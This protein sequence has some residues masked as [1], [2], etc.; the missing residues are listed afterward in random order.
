MREAGDS[1]TATFIEEYADYLESHIEDW[2][3]TT[4]GSLLEGQSSY[5]LRILPEQ[6]GQQNPAED[7][8]E[9]ILNIANHA[10]GEES[11]FPAR[12]VVDGDFWNWSATAFAVRK[13]RTSL[14]PSR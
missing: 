4:T 14:Q 2:T 5:Y 11:D 6:V 13:T 1:E 3:L 9:R 7:K 8:E 12:D 10:P